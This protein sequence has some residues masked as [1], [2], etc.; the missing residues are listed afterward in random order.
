MGP[1]AV[2]AV[3]TLGDGPCLMTGG[4]FWDRNDLLCLLDTL[5]WIG[6]KQCAT[7]EPIAYHFSQI[8]SILDGIVERRPSR[9]FSDE[10]LL[11]KYREKIHMLRSLGCDC[12]DC[13]DNC[14]CSKEA[15]RCT[16]IC[17]VHHEEGETSLYCMLERRNEGD[18]KVRT[19]TE[20]T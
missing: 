19:E 5:L 17:V 12:D 2:H 13:A 9:W 14:P 8:I 18:E 10:V 11:A 6:K 1:G 16:P 3:H 7:N 4:M 20:T 15:R